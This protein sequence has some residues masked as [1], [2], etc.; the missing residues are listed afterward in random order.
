MK[1]AIL[2]VLTAIAVIGIYFFGF[3]RGFTKTTKATFRLI[4]RTLERCEFTIEQRKNFFEKMHEIVE[5]EN[6]E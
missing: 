5:E 1:T 3:Y 4:D 6:E 2:T